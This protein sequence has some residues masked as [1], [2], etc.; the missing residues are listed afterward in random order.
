M[1]TKVQWETVKGHAGLQYR[2]FGNELCFRF[3]Q[4]QFAIDFLGVMPLATAIR[5][6]GEL[7]ENRATGA[8]SQTYKDMRG[9]KHEQAQ[10]AAI[11]EKRERKRVIAEERFAT[12]NTIATFWDGV[13]WPERSSYGNQTKRDS[14]LG[15]FNRWIRPDLGDI[16]LQELTSE[17]VKKATDKVK[18]AGFK[19]STVD[20]VYKTMQAMWNRAVFA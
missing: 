2:K 9:E 1:A 20:A 5:I 6:A 18:E 3:R 12:E 19:A 11:V 8:G 16:P 10:E 7:R 15:S 17:D 13:Y 14:I 4:R